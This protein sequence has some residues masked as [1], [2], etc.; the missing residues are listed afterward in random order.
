[1]PIRPNC[2]ICGNLKDENSGYCR[3]CRRVY[4]Y[5]RRSELNMIPVVRRQNNADY[6]KKPKRGPDMPYNARAGWRRRSIQNP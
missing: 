2:P 3:R 5:L 1:M 6:A 4:Q